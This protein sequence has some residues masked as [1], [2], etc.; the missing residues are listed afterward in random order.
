MQIHEAELD[1]NLEGEAFDS[2]EQERLWD[3]EGQKEE[4]SH[5]K[6]L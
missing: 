4:L 1:V 5:M 2:N 3:I 6:K